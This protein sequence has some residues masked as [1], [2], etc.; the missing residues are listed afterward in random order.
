MVIRP[1]KKFLSGDVLT[2]TASILV[3]VTSGG[4]LTPEVTGDDSIGGEVDRVVM[5][6]SP[7]FTNSDESGSPRT[8]GKAKNGSA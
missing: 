3:A 8:T 7:A 6:A 5:K 2:S 1:P 4:T